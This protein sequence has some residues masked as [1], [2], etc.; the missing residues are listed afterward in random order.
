MKRRNAYILFVVLALVVLFLDRFTKIIAVEQLS[1]GR[2]IAFIPRVFDFTL[3]FNEGG[4]FGIFAGG[5]FFFIVVAIIVVAAILI[6]LLRTK[7]F[8]MPAVIALSLIVAGAAGNAYDRALTGRVPDFIHTL[9]IDF[10]VFNIAD[11]ALTIG[12]IG[13]LLIIVVYWFKQ[14]DDTK[15]EDSKPEVGQK[16]QATS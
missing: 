14:G 10:P 6:Y 15:D 1:D 7:S 11:I 16:E 12:E 5:R 3:V 8:F 4:A 13:L 9:F 2:S